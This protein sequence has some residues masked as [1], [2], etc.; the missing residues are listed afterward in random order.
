MRLCGRWLGAVLLV[1]GAQ[2]M[3]QSTEMAFEVAAVKASTADSP[4][5]STK[6][7]PGQ[8][9][10]SNTPLGFLIR[11]AYDIDEGRLIGAPKGLE[12]VRYDIVAKIPLGEV[13]PG[14][15]RK[16]MKSLLAER[17]N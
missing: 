1:C 5:M 3:A 10:T 6:Q 7:L 16:M 15:T 13:A 8:F 14:R 12:S 4:P 2:L 9:T 11:W 17:F